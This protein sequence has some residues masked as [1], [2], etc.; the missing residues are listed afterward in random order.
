MVLKVLRIQYEF[1]RSVPIEL[2]N[3]II[4]AGLELGRHSIIFWDVKRV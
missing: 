4:S 3:S 1:V 2:K